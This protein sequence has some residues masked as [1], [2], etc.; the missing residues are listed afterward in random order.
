MVFSPISTQG[1]QSDDPPEHRRASRPAGGLHLTGLP[2]ILGA[3]ATGIALSAYLPWSA[4]LLSLPFLSA[5]LW[6]ALRSSRG[7]A[8]IAAVFFVSSGFCLGALQEAPPAGGAHVAALA[9]EDILA[10]QGRVLSIASR[11][12]EAWN[13]DVAVES[14]SR[15]GEAAVV[16]GT[17]RLTVRE[18]E[19]HFLP[20]ETI[21]FRSRLRTPRLFG[22]PGEFD[23]PRFLAARD[24]HATA[25]VQ[26]M[27]DIAPFAPEQGR[28]P[29]IERW[30][31]SIARTIDDALD[32]ASAPL[33]RALVIGD[34]GGISPEQRT[35]LARGGVSH[36]FSISGLHL[37]LVALFFFSAARFFYIRS[38]RLLLLSPPARFLPPTL[39]APL[40]VYLLLSGSAFPTLRAFLAAA[41][42]ALLFLVG[43]HT[44]ALKLLTA[45]AFIVLLAHPLALFEASFQLSF[46]GV[47][48]IV[49]LVPRWSRPIEHLPAVILRP[50]QLMMT[51]LAATVATAPFVLLH[52]SLVA[53][54]GLLTNMLAVPLIGFLC[55]PLGLAGALLSPWFAEGAHLL[56][57][58]CAAILQFVLG[59]VELAVS[60]PGLTGWRYHPTLAE[61]AGAATLVLALLLP[62]TRT[63]FPVRATIAAVSLLLI[64]LPSPSPRTLT[65]TALSVGQGDATLLSL[66]DGRHY[67][68]DGGGLYGSRFDTGERLVAPALGRFGVRSLEAVILTHDHPDHSKGLV[69]VLDHFPVRA[70]WSGAPVE[71][72]N[73]ELRAAIARS[74]VTTIIFSP[75]WYIFEEGEDAL[76]LYAPFEDGLLND[77]SLVLYARQGGNGVLLTGDLESAGVRELIAAEA[78]PGPVTLLKLPHHGSR[79]SEPH[80][81]LDHLEPHIGFA[82]AGFANVYRLPHAEVKEAMRLRGLPM[83]STNVDGTVRFRAMQEGWRSARW[84]RGIF[85]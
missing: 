62:A 19:P 75:G 16:R 28:G 63:R 68:I 69:Y 24:I 43:R 27:R 17:V 14:I 29:S 52:F 85:R 48:G 12:E 70:F 53:P 40:L 1:R 37:G 49:V 2:F 8:L 58:A 57:R 80:L 7:A 82:S 78:P 34:K 60:A 11:P 47:L 39:I 18:G 71:E 41:A 3:F 4:P 15:R 65:V 26:H 46:A 64:L 30:R 36:L 22:T 32:P 20:G 25:F 6:L 59:V 23:F 9:S 83:Y 61:V 81:L 55:V 45:V 50:A 38:E 51:T 42:T 35:V 73:P 54:A 21:R 33:V 5:V 72:L 67:L 74:G 31:R 13:I 77:T 84:Q 76:A 10:V 66:R 56:F 44:P 79:G